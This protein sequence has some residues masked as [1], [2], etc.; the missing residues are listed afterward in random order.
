MLLL[1][2]TDCAIAPYFF[3]TFKAAH[4]KW[5]NHQESDFWGPQST[6]TKCMTIQRHLRKQS[7]LNS[8][9]FVKQ[10]SIIFF[11]V[12]GFWLVCGWVFARFVMGL[13]WGHGGYRVEVWLKEIVGGGVV[14]RVIEIRE[15]SDR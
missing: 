1:H 11:T 13:S 15:S 6:P 9:H 5:D 3:T 8:Y 2:Y 14:K 4:C 10:S 7:F 12:V